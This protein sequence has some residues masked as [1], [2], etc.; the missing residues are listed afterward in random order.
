MLITSLGVYSY[1]INSYQS[2][3]YKMENRDGQ[4]KLMENKKKLFENEMS[5]M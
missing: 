4:I 3:K 5:R 2:T 1:L